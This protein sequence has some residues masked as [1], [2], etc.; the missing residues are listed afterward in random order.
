MRRAIGRL[1]AWIGG[2]VVVAVVLSLVITLYGL[3]HKKAVPSKTILEVNLETVLSEDPPDDPLAKLSGGHK[4]DLH[5]ITF[6]LERAE[7]DPRVVGLIA[8]LGAA[9]VGIAQVQELRDAITRFR[10]T[11]KFALA[12]SE[13]FGEFASGAGAYYLASA[14]DEV[15]LQPSGDVGLVGVKMESQFLRGTLDKLGINPRMDHRYEYKN[16]MNAFT[17]TK[18]TP[19]HR[20]AMAKVGESV[21]NQLVRGIAE[22]RKLSPE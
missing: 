16:A 20:E 12:F 14:F 9:S 2:L 3:R 8:R 19:A 7:S 15:W 21:F 10:S 11:G 4:A 17:E 5:D 13:T 1:L 22:C 6:A 18:F